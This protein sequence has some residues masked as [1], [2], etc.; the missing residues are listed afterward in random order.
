MVG[1]NELPDFAYIDEARVKQP[2]FSTPV[3]IHMGRRRLA[4]YFT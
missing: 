3:T 4:F 1:I 2:I